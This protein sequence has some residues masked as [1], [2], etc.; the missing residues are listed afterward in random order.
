MCADRPA[1][2]IVS[3]APAAGKSTLAARLAADL[4]LPL[5]TKDR[6]KERL[7]DVLPAADRTESNQLGIA[8]YA[9]LYAATGWLLDA[10]AGLVIESNF[11][12]NAS[13]QELRPLVERARAVLIHCETSHQETIRRYT[14]RGARHP[15]HFDAEMIPTL[16]EGLRAARFQPP[17]LPCPL[18]RVDTTNG[19]TPG[20]DRVLAFARHSPRREEQA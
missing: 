16:K 12:R 17:D 9:L 2:V 4:A 13:E 10:G 19:Y 7:G 5:L 3:G 14:E 20:F 18:L 1:L 8:A 15:V 11:W 6:I